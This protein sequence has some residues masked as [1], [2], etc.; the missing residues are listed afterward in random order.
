MRS[1]ALLA[2]VLAIGCGGAPP[3]TEN[4]IGNDGGDGGD[5]TAFRADGS[6]A[7]PFARVLDAPEL[8]DVGDP[9]EPAQ[10]TVLGTMVDGAIKVG[11]QEVRGSW[12]SA[13]CVVTIETTDGVF[14]GDDFLCSADR[15]DETVT[16]AAVELSIDGGVAI[17]R[18]RV[19]YQIDGSAPDVE[20]HVIRC[21]LTGTL[22]C[23]PPPAV[24]GYE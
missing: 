8:A 13:T 24:G 10:V 3:R 4:P 11:L 1:L 2:F 12:T 21:N 6:L 16:T 14:V 9:E 22:S 7:G 20:T 23:T 5:P 15:S 17:L 18:F 19:S